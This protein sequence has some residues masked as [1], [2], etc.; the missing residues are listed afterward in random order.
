MTL[1]RQF[2]PMVPASHPSIKTDFYPKAFSYQRPQQPLAAET[3]SSSAQVVM[4][5]PLSTASA[6]HILHSQFSSREGKKECGHLE[7]LPILQLRFPHDLPPNQKD[8]SFNN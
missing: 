2:H 3:M 8:I 5:L 4:W 6:K 7:C 1:V